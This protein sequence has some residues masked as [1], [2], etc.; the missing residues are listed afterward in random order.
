MKTWL[1]RLI[2]PKS[3]SP[4]RKPARTRL[5]AES[6]EPR[7]VMSSYFD[8]NS[9]A[10]SVYGSDATDV[11]EVSRVAGTFGTNYDT[12]RVTVNGTPE[13]NVRLYKYVGSGTYGYWVPNVTSLYVDAY[14]GNDTVRNNTGLPSTL[15]GGWGNDTVSGGSGN[16]TLIGWVGDDVLEGGDGDDVIW[17]YDGN[18][19]L[20]GG[21]G[22]DQLYGENGNDTLWGWYGNDQLSGGEGIDNLWGYYGNDTLW[23]DAGAD[24]LHGEYD[25]DTIYGGRGNDTAWGDAGADYIA[26]DEDDDVLIGGTE[27]DTINGFD[28]NDTIWGEDGSDRIG[29]QNGNDTIYG[30]RGSDTLWGDAGNDY[31]AGDENDDTIY[32]GTEND[33]LNGMDGNDN[34]FGEAGFDT[35]GGQSGDDKLWGGADFDWLYGDEGNDWLDAGSASETAVGGDGRDFNAYVTAINGTYYTDVVQ[36]Q[37]ITAKTCWVMAGLAGATRTGS[38]DLSTRIQYLGNGVYRVNWLRADGRGQMFE[39]VTFTGDTLPA[40]AVADERQAAWA[41]SWVVLYQRAIL[42]QAGRSW[43]D[44]GSGGCYVEPPLYLGRDYTSV[45]PTRLDQ[46]FQAVFAGKA[47]MAF[48]PAGNTKAEEL[49]LPTWHWYTVLSVTLTTSGWS[50]T[51]YN[52]HGNER[53]LTGEEFSACVNGVSVV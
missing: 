24:Y 31:L 32:G 50:V 8:P 30:G 4:I 34:L 21:M 53:V 38:L 12:I 1:R 44:P 26:G 6:L 17:A 40:D 48:I 35:L 49:G 18:D 11:I 51:V 37:S 27:N 19:F 28:G 15:H 22:N 29:G 33:I 36:G 2:S 52:P 16:D 47:V 43:A 20:N 45:D 3:F 7:D 23:G 46:I 10:I 13:R 5:E 42:T 41:E 25:N 9:G 39:D 14:G